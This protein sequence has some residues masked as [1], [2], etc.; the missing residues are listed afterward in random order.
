MP[1]RK[2]P[3]NHRN[4]TGYIHTDKG[5][6]YTEFE[7]G[8]ERDALILVE[9]D[10]NIKLFESQPR[11]FYFTHGGKERR[12]T[13]DIL[14]RYQDGRNFYVEVKYRDDLKKDW[15]TLKPKFKAAIHQLKTEKN[16]RFKI[17]TEV[18]IRTQYLKNI[19]FL[20]SYK[21]RSVEEYQVKTILKILSTVKS[22]KI[23][24]L[25]SACTLDEMIQAEFLHAIWYSVANRIIQIDLFSEIHMQSDLWIES[26][27]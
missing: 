17:W 14:I 8:L 7:S 4:I 9:F 27:D 18:E 2:I 24:E 10:R 5:G 26:V 15:E 3:R 12:Y 16:T 22:L 11:T 19:T 23:N 20:L 6:E 1:A 13:P 25:L 21:K